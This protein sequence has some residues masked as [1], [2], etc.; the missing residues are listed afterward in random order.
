M[1]MQVNL[2]ISTPNNGNGDI[3]KVMR[4]LL[5]LSVSLLSFLVLILNT[6]GQQSYALEFVCTMEYYCQ[7]SGSNTDRS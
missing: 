1:Q 6:F 4:I 7:I 5:V 3:P 2:P